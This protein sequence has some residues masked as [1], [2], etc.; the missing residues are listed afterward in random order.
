MS[1]NRQWEKMAGALRYRVMASPLV[2]PTAIEFLESD[3]WFH[4]S[5]YA[6]ANLIKFINRQELKPEW[7][8]RLR[9]VVLAAVDR[10][11]RREF[12]S[13]CRLACKV[14]SEQLRNQ[15]SCILENKNEDKGVR[16]RARWVLDYLTRKKT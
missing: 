4:G 13:Y 16:R 1:K 6:K 5:G 15:L 2:V 7:S 10:E 8:K 14:N 9:K 12:R 11:D 3:P